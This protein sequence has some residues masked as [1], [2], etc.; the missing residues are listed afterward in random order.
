MIQYV[1]WCFFSPSSRKHAKRQTQ[2][3]W[4]RSRRKPLYFPKVEKKH[5]PTYPTDQWERIKKEIGNKIGED[6]AFIQR[7]LAMWRELRDKCGELKG[8]ELQIEG[9]LKRLDDDQHEI[10][11]IDTNFD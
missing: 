4:L 11:A 1:G 10:Q 5:Q 6:D 8:R 2:I 9:L 3:F 7:Q